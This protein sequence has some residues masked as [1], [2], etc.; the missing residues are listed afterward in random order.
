MLF[1]SL[2]LDPAAATVLLTRQFRYPVYANG[3]PAWLIEVCAGLLDGEEPAIAASRE[4]VEETGY[5]P[6]TLDHVFDAYMS[7]G[8]LTEKIAC[9]VGSYVSGS[10]EN[11]G[12]GLEDEGEDIEVLELPLSTALTMIKTGKITDGKTIMLLQWAALNRPELVR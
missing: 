12:G 6:V 9:F 2:L 7:P 3:D 10:P 1:R 5:R 11:A 8:S 4:A